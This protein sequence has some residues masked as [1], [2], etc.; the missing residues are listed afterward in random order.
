MVIPIE[1]ILRP[2]NSK[3]VSDTLMQRQNT[4]DNLNVNQYVP[5]WH[6]N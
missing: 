4:V 2:D 3:N 5:I 6:K 1:Y